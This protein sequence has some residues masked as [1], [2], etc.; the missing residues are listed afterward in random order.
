MRG[1]F[2]VRFLG[3][4]RR[5][6][7]FPL[8]DHMRDAAE[9]KASLIGQHLIKTDTAELIAH[10]SEVMVMPQPYGTICAPFNGMS[11]CA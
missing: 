11:D 5:G 7:T 10:V 2:Q 8:P 1:N 9:L 3:E 4:G 6:N